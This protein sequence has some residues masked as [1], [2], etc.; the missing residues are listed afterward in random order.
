ML[1]APEVY[2]VQGGRLRW[3]PDP[4]TF[5]SSGFVW[6]KICVVPDGALDSLS[7]GQPL[8]AR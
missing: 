4:H 1:S 2:V 5:E 3:V 7:K 8:P 6:G